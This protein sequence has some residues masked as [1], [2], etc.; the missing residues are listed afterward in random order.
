MTIKG[1]NENQRKIGMTEEIKA[2]HAIEKLESRVLA[3]IRVL[4]G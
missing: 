1:L 2:T 4:A 3:G